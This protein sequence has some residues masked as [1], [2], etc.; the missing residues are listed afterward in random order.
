MSQDIKF[1][2]LDWDTNEFG[3]DV[4]RLRINEKITP[5]ELKEQYDSVKSKNPGLL[6]IEV[7]SQI[8]ELLLEIQKYGFRYLSSRI[9]L[10][11]PPIYNQVNVDILENSET[12]TTHISQQEKK[13]FSKLFGSSFKGSRFALDP[14]FGKKI[15]EMVYTKMALS[16]FDNPRFISHILR[17][18]NKIKGFITI[19]NETGFISTIAVRHSEREKGYASKIMNYIISNYGTKELTVATT[20]DNIGAIKLYIK[21]RFQLKQ[22]FHIFHS[23]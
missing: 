14:R 7:H 19:D 12:I 13:E 2:K 3:F 21:N 18:Q 23:F 11:R 20:A 6:V 5:S 4:Y 10:F 22:I 8:T 1:I 15:S 17:V 16:Y 9:Y